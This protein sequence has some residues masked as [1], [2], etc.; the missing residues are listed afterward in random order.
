MLKSFFLMLS[1]LWDINQHMHI[2]STYHTP[3]RSQWFQICT[4]TEA[5][6]F[7][8]QWQQPGRC[9]LSLFNNWNALFIKNKLLLPCLVC[10][11]GL[12]AG[13]WAK[14]SLVWFPV[15]HMPGLWARSL[16]GCMQEVTTQGC[17][18]LSLPFPLS[19]NK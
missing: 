10:L 12:G 13:L 16:V 7:Q 19:E 6:T 2:P 15:R 5:F 8:K 11:S 3:E 14:G 17:F 1:C 9:N 4:H 18:S